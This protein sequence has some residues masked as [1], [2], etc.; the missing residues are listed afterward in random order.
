VWTGS[1]RR[2]RAM[3]AVGVVIDQRAA[4]LAARLTTA[5]NT[6]VLLHPHPNGIALYLLVL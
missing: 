3:T 2:A 6:R 5:L 4:E 1:H